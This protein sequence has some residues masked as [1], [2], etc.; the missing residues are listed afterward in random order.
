MVRRTASS[1]D[2]HRSSP[3]ARDGD[4]R[5]GGPGGERH[6]PRRDRLLD[7]GGRRRCDGRGLRLCDSG[8]F[9]DR[10]CDSGC[11]GDRLCDSGCFG[12]RL[13]LRR[14]N[15]AG[16][17]KRQRI[18]VALPVGG[19]AQPEGD[20]G[21]ADLGDAARTDGRDDV[22]FVDAIPSGGQ[23]R[24]EME[25]RDGVSVGRLDRHGPPARRDGARE[26]DDARCGRA[27]VRPGRRAE[28]DAAM[29]TRC[30]RMRAVERERAQHRTVDGPRPRLRC[31]DGNR[32]RTERQNSESPEHVSL[33]VAS[34]EN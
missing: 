4:N 5:R 18:D 16:R 15:L 21:L 3:A 17:Q 27:H 26:A 32:E 11:F 34:F 13:C 29:L 25:E 8:C 6:P 24:A 19:L 10:L 22:S 12:D 23:E 28:I 30:V 31:R 2:G 33:L 20:I 9:G 1:A 14:L 7:G